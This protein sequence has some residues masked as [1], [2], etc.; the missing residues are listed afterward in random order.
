[1]RFVLD[2]LKP[3]KFQSTVLNNATIDVH[4]GMIMLYLNYTYFINKVWIL[5]G[6]VHFISAWGLRVAR[7]TVV[8]NS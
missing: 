8:G 1:M 2:A 5:L 4:M 3:R 6:C 7:S